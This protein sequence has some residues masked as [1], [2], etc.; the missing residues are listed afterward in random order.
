MK[1]L[2]KVSALI[3]AMALAC[4]FFGCSDGNSTSSFYDCTTTVTATELTFAD[5]NWTVKAVING[6]GFS[7]E[8]N[9][10]AS[11]SNGSFSFTSGTGT[12][13]VDLASMMSE[14]ELNDFNQLTDEQKK[15]MIEAMISSAPEEA[16]VTINGTK[17]TVKAALDAEELA[18]MQSSMDLSELPNS[19]TIKTNSDNTKYIISLTEDGITETIYIS[20]D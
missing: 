20:K 13:T 14:E 17:V 2:I 4:A 10:K 1:K 5:G 16:T 12:E 9:I 7:T 8:M 15:Q 19:A 18:E 3:A 11:V 6:E